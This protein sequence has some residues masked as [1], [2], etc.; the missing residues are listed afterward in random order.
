MIAD[1]EDQGPPKE[2]EIVIKLGPKQGKNQEGD[3]VFGKDEIR[4]DLTTEVITGDKQ[5]KAAAH[6]TV[7][8]QETGAKEEP[9]EQHDYYKKGYTGKQRD[10]FGAEGARNYDMDREADM[11][12]RKQAE[13]WVQNKTV[14]PDLGPRK[15]IDPKKKKRKAKVIESV[16]SKKYPERLALPT[17]R[18]GL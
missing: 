3:Y 17:G 14:A 7:L 10:N 5:Y 12:G 15:T 2:E 1:P 11:L 6:G 9:L 13:D 8:L 16:G 18:G 4:K